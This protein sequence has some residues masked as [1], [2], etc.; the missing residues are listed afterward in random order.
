MTIG[1]EGMLGVPRALG[2]DFS[3]LMA[4]SVVPCE[5]MRVPVQS[6]LEA[7][8]AGGSL[9]RLVKKYAAYC[10]FLASQ[11]TACS[12]THTVEQRVCRRLLMAHDW[13]GKHEF[14][15]THELLGDMLGVCR[16]SITLVAS[17][18]QDARFI[19]YRRGTIKILNRRGLESASCNCYK[20]AAAAYDSIVMKSDGRH[21]DR[22]P[23][24]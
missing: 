16:Q 19:A 4:V 21:A 14:L 24:A 11:T 17:A 1:K 23:L 18:L 15:L 5:A 9:E 2:L 10:M 6:F 7:L 22:D 8:R 20:I 12:T 3:P 13:V